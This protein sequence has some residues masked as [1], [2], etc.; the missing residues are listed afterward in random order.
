M[1]S[2][3]GI[4]CSFGSKC[5]IIGPRVT[6]ENRMGE[7]L[8]TLFPLVL[9]AL[10]AALT[11]WLDQA[12]QNP[13]AEREKLLVHDPD[14]MIEKLVATR[15]DDNGRIRDTLQASRM[16]HF[17]DDDSTELTLPRFVSVARG[18]PLA[19]T[20]KQALV[21]S[22]GSD[23]YF[24]GDVHA[25]RAP[26]AGKSTLLVVTDYL[27]LMPDDNI[28]KTDRHVTIS[29][30]NMSIDAIGMELNN[31]TRILKLNAGVRGVYR[32]ANTKARDAGN[33]RNR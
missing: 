27:H 29:D 4:W 31:E 22:N 11:Y 6:V 32:D 14:F 16:V 8:S 5:W 23:L 19:V 1:Q 21:S 2:L 33:A 17:P 3:R 18:T 20:S 28:A 12:V 30:A 15:M 13:A 26:Q 10:L 7:R 25:T 9:A 24:Q